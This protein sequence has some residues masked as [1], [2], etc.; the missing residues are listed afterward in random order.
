MNDNHASSSDPRRRNLAILGTAA[1]VLVILAAVALVGQQSNTSSPAQ[2]ETFFPGLV[3]EL[4]SV[5]KI[6]IASKKYGAF[7]VVFKPQ[8]GW[9]LPG[10]GDFPASFDAVRK[11]LIGMATLQ[12]VERKTARADWLAYLGLT[13]PAK[14]GD[15]VLI[16]LEGGGKKLAALIA[17]RADDSAAVNGESGL[18][19]RRPDE[20][21]SWL[22]RGVL[23]VQSDPAAWLE[24]TVLDLNRTRIRQADVA[25]ASGESYSVLR[26]KPGDADFH[27]SVMPHGREAASFSALDDVGNSIVDF[28]FD[29]IR[30][31]QELDF[32]G[33]TRLIT[34]TF[35][36]LRITLRVSKIGAEYWATV[37]ADAE[38]GRAQAAIEARGI[39]AHAAGWA[40]KLPSYKGA[41]MMAS[42]E[43]LLKPLSDKS[44]P[45]PSKPAP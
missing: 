23:E 6:H 11:T 3:K 16:T 39:D 25:T 10:R 12:T 24:K 5:T 29:D 32:S 40:Y 13:D 15:G 9:V 28:S 26:D 38:P 8:S 2:S 18:F 41:Q 44:G 33:A 30:R 22:A 17:G 43:S 20:T 31:A 42:L 34:S 37:Y 45:A 14:G 19:V 36:G 21:Q 27:L 7:D 1:L 4:R 35:D